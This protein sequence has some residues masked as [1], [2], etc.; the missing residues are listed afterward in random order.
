MLIGLGFHG[1]LWKMGDLRPWAALT[2]PGS[3]LT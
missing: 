3:N 1:R 2:Y